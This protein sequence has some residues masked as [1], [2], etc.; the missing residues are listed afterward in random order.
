M[1]SKMPKL[2]FQLVLGLLLMAFT[3]AACNNKKK[4]EKKIETDTT[5]QKP[6]DPGN[7]SDTITTLMDTVTQKPV[8]P[9]N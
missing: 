7:L 4:D 3:F 1:R 8:D 5:I 6:V 9:G 2:A